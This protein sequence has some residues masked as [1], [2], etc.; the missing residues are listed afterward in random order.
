MINKDSKTILKF[1]N[2]QIDESQIFYKRKFVFA[3]V[4]LR[5][6]L[7]GH[8][9]LCPTRVEKHYSNLTE[10]EVMELWISAK[11]IANN[12]KKY[13]HTDSIQISIQDG[14]NSGQTVEH[15]HFHIIPIPSNYEAKQ[16]DVSEKKDRS[17]EDM[18]KEAEEYRNNFVF[19]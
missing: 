10:T 5:P 11:N 4:N 6:F 13:Y 18:S 15:C 3:F 16:I 8:V 9:L 1:A 17:K 2:I 14:E 7:P 12:L 19:N